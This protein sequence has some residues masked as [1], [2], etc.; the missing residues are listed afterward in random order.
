MYK[1]LVV[2]DEEIIRKGLRQQIK[3]EQLGFEIIGEAGNGQ[4]ALE[5]VPVLKPDVILTDVKMPVINGIELMKLLK[6]SYPNIKVV[7]LSGYSDFEYARK[8]VEFS[9]FSYILKPTKEKNILEVFTNLKEELDK[10]QN[11]QHQFN[12]IKNKAQERLLELKGKILGDIISGNYGESEKDRL[13]QYLS[14]LDIPVSGNYGLV[15]LEIEMAGEIPEDFTKRQA[16]IG[17]SF[18]AAL[19][20]FE[21][22]RL[23]EV[24]KSASPHTYAVVLYSPLKVSGKDVSYIVEKARDFLVEDISAGLPE[25]GAIHVSAGIS[26]FRTDIFSLTKCSYEAKIAL[27]YKFFKGKGSINDLSECNSNY[28]DLLE[29]DTAGGLSAKEEYKLLDDLAEAILARHLNTAVALVNRYFDMIKNSKNQSRDFIYVKV[30]E[31]LTIAIDRLR[32]RNCD[33]DRHMKRGYHSVL[34]GI[35]SNGTILEVKNHVVDLVAG[36]MD[37]FALQEEEKL[38]NQSVIQQIKEYLDKNYAKKVT[39][40]ELAH[41]AFMNPSY[42]SNLFRQ[43][44]GSTF[45]EYLTAA[46]INKARELL[47][48]PEMKIYEVAGLVGYDDFRHF[49]KLFKKITGVSPLLY[50]EN[51][52]NRER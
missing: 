5:L 30:I 21:N 19:K 33:T 34:G 20:K 13:V 10:S 26:S 27:G 8:A 2:E 38:K 31:L 52:M 46:R 16:R 41:L 24:Q 23:V 51:M 29:D 6:S 22:Y 1:L 50:R 36:M 3:W 9:A 25:Y 39:L 47:S 44:T 14:E 35:I 11:T 43:K 37:S 15:M 42:L 12:H 7:I 28:Q 49:S 18:A 45:I 17:S 4:E 48:N 40:E 32:E